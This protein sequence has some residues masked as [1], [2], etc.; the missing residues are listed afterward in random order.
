MTCVVLLLQSCY[1]PLLESCYSRVEAGSG[2]LHFLNQ[3]RHVLEEEVVQVL[4]LHVLQLELGPV[5]LSHH[6]AVLGSC[7]ATVGAGQG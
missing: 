3:A 2:V 5:L 7:P 1:F 4:L 6:P